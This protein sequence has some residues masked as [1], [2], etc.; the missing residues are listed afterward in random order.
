MVMASSQMT[1]FEHGEERLQPNQVNRTPQDYI[2]K[3]II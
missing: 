2:N 3:F 1:E